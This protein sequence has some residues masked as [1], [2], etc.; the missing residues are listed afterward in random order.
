MGEKK[1]LLIIYSL[2]PKETSDEPEIQRKWQL[3]ELL[4]ME[5]KKFINFSLPRLGREQLSIHHVSS[6]LDAA[7]IPPRR[8]LSHHLFRISLFVMLTFLSG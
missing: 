8:A 2:A 3:I 1:N 7:Y 5:R 4:E 6:D